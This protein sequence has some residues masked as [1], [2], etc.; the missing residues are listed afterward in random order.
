MMFE[1]MVFTCDEFHEVHGSDTLIAEYHSVCPLRGGAGT[2]RNTYITVFCFDG[3]N[4]IVLFKEYLN[5]QRLAD[6]MPSVEDP[7]H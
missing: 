5:P 4:R 1:R 3:D 2:Y 6:L 7:A